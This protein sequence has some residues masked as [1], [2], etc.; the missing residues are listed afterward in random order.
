VNP[1]RAQAFTQKIIAGLA[2]LDK[3]LPY[4]RRLALSMLTGQPIDPAMN[5]QVLAV[6]Q[7]SFTAEPSTEGGTQAP[8]AQPQFG[9]ISKPEPTPADRRAEGAS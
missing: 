9:S 3:P 5:P 2:Q 1:E 6:L 4:H 7:G 8:K